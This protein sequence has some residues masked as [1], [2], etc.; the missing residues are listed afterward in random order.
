MTP[1]FTG[2]PLLTDRTTIETDWACGMKRWWYKEEGGIGI[3]PAEEAVWFKQGRDYHEDFAELAQAADPMEAALERIENLRSLMAATNDQLALE[4]LCRRAGW[5]AANALWLEPATRKDYRT[6]HVEHELVLEREALWLAVT[7]DRVLERLSDSQI[8]YRDYKGVGGWGITAN[9]LSS[10]PYQI[11]L[12]SVLKAIEEELGRPVGFG[13]IVGL[14][15]GQEK[16]GKLRHPYVWS[17]FS[18][19]GADCTTDYY[20]AKRKG[21]TLRP[22]WEYAG[23]I[24][25]W[26]K[27][28]GPE[29]ASG[30]FVFSQ[31]IFLN[32][33]LLTDLVV[34]RT[35][36]EREVKLFRE[37]CQK[38]KRLRMLHFEPKF[39]SCRPAIGSPCPYLAACHNQSV[40]DNPLGSGMYVKRTPHHDLELI[41]MEGA[42][43]GNDT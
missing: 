11:Q 14:S 18:D 25:E 9:W 1:N 40:N 27:R 13:Q 8:V 16:E 20:E 41:S 30:Q 21:L 12:H 22:V 28:L 10:W 43:N 5:V 29:V 24:L 17:Y 31:P 4:T 34:S 26:V 33:R 39:S 2:D 15:K 38:D 7:P 36:R 23:G 35:R 32:E 37:A 3:V 6:L 19:D 42:S